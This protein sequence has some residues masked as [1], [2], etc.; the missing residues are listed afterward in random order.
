MLLLWLLGILYSSADAVDLGINYKLLECFDYKRNYW[1]VGYAFHTSSV[2]FKDECLRVCLSALIRGSRCKSAM[3]IPGD[4]QC[5]ISDQ[6]QLSRPDLFVENDAHNTFTVNYFR[7][8]CVD[9]PQKEGGRLEA[10]LTGF[11][12]GEGILELAQRKGQ[13]P[14]L[15]A[16][17]TGLQENKNFHLI[18]MPDIE[19]SSCYKAGIMNSHKGQKLITIDSDSRGMAIQPWTDIDFHILDDG[20]I[21]KVYTGPVNHPCITEYRAF[22]LPRRTTNAA[23]Q[24]IRAMWLP[25]LMF[26]ICFPPFLKQKHIHK[27][28]RWKHRQNINTFNPWAVPLSSALPRRVGSAAR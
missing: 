26:Y 17:M 19:L 7:N 21:D 14:K 27:E 13:N 23:R 11:R 9:P 25:K 12:G 28:E 8:T 20:V 3:H 15:L 18:Y 16:I 2:E 5:V 24:T 10:R 1:L 4:D 22:A 6:D